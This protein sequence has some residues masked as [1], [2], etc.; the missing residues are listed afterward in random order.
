MANKTVVV[1]LVALAAAAVVY[2]TWMKTKS[3]GLLEKNSRDVSFSPSYCLSGLGGVSIDLPAIDSG[4]YPD[5]EI[6]T[7][8]TKL[9]QIRSRYGA[10]ITNIAAAT[11]VSES[12]IYSFIYIESSGNPNQ[13]TGMNYGLMQVGT[14]S[15]TDIIFKEY[16]QGRLGAPEQ[17]ILRRCIGTRLDDIYKIKSLGTAQYIYPADLTDPECNILL[18]AILIG[19]LMDESLQSDGTLRMDKVIVRYNMGY[20]AYSRGNTLPAT[21][22]DTVATVNGTTSDYILKMIG[23]NGVLEIIEAGNCGN[24]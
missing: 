4:Y 2:Y 19:Q 9:A 24:S 7:I 5:S 14:N 23:K 10:L 15:A 3:V 20:Y 6:D 22:A 21:I 16:K 11:N 17:A 12:I 1:S 13:Q 18:G 8:R